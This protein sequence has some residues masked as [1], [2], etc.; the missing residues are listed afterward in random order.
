MRERNELALAGFARKQFG[1]AARSQLIEVGV[2]SKQ[3]DYLLRIGRLERIFQSV[4]RVAGVPSSWEQEL[5]AA[6]WAGGVRG[7]FA[8]HR[9]ATQLWTLPG[10]KELV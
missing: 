3:I 4:Y 1:V 6:C 9:A 2:T 10:G 8:S 7:A 5:L